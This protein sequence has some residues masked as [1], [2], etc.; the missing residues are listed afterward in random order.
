MT[1]EA[2]AT[3]GLVAELGGFAQRLS[4][5]ELPA[6]VREMAKTRILDT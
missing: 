6:E 5:E 2:T 3:E 1:A 4:Y